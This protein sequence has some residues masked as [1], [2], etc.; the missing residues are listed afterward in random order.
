MA[1]NAADHTGPFACA[2]DHPAAGHDVG[3]LDDQH[4]DGAVVAGLHRGVGSVG[5][6]G[7][8]GV[9]VDLAHHQLA[10]GDSHCGPCHSEVAQAGGADRELIGADFNFFQAVPLGIRVPI[11]ALGVVH[12]GQVVIGL[13]CDYFQKRLIVGGDG[14]WKVKHGVLFQPH[15]DLDGGVLDPQCREGLREVQLGGGVGEDVND[16]RAQ[17]ETLAVWRAHFHPGG[18]GHLA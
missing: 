9:G 6:V 10:V 16:D 18:V 13:S 3:L 2:L 17:R 4:R 7:G 15:L 11:H 14:T 1:G 12:A 8:V 5:K